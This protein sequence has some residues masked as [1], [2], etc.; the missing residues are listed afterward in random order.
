MCGVFKEITF[1]RKTGK[2]IME[3]FSNGT[4]A[5]QWQYRNCLSCSKYNNDWLTK[6][7]CRCEINYYIECGFGSGEIPQ[8]ILDR[9]GGNECEE[10]DDKSPVVK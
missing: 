2:C 6:E 7:G 3:I 4:E 9:M 5:M 10:R 8:G 1:N